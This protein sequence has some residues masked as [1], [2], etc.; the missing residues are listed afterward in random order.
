MAIT[1][2][3][4][5]KIY[6]IHT[7]N[8]KFTIYSEDPIERATFSWKDGELFVITE[9]KKMKKYKI[10]ETEFSLIR[11]YTALHNGKILS[12]TPSLNSEYIFTTGEDHLVKVWD[13]QFRGHI[14]PAYQAYNCGEYLD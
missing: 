5:I 12:I 7:M 3:L 4:T 8:Q 2:A 1:D 11:E 10:S 14:N 6:N 13:Y 9:N